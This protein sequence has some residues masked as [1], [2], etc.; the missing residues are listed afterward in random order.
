MN[1]FKAAGL[2]CRSHS[3]SLRITATLSEER[4]LARGQ[5]S[6]TGCL[7]ATPS[8]AISARKI[9]HRTQTGS[10]SSR[11]R[12][13]SLTSRYPIN[14]LGVLELLKLQEQRKEILRDL[15]VLV[16]FIFHPLGRDCWSGIHSGALSL[17]L[18]ERNILFFRCLSKIFRKKLSFLIHENYINGSV[19]VKI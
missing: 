11:F 18:I 4:D 16:R 10:E 8:A 14:R 6:P 12:I 9:T 15:I 5:I 1:Y 7:I 13:V 2:G 3:L 19:I 17:K